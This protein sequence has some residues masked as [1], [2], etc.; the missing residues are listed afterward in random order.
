V[1]YCGIIRHW[2]EKVNA[3]I[4]NIKWSSHTWSGSNDTYDTYIYEVTLLTPTLIRTV[5]LCE[6][7]LLIMT[8]EK[9]FKDLIGN[10][11][12]K[13]FTKVEEYG[14]TSEEKRD[15]S[16][17]TLKDRKEEEKTNSK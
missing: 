4:N 11:R 12:Y 5:E 9:Y 8:N 14:T 7:E 16:E 3:F 13:D 6:K 2:V 10:D 15:S 17:T 1:E